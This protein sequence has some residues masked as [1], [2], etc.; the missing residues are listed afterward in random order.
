M[1]NKREV[2]EVPDDTYQP[3]RAEQDEPIKL[4]VPKGIGLEVALKRIL[5]PVE[6]RKIS[7]K[8][9]RERRSHDQ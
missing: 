7:A 9:H 5:R 8:E 3:T 6:L 4:D 2:I 1:S